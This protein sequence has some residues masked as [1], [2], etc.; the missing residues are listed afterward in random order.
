MPSILQYYRNPLGSITY[1]PAGFVQLTWSDAPISPPELQS[2]YVHTLQALRHHAARKLLTDQRR[3]QPL[4]LAEQQ[5]I[6]EHWIPR[7][8]QECAYSHCAIVESQE[9]VGRQAARAV[10]QALGTNPPLFHY[11]AEEELARTWL[12]QND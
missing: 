3:R 10:G 7:A 1:D 11:F 5:W 2:I 9:L 4:P 8:V 12:R 6:V